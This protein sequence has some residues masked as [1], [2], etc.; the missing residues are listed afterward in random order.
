MSKSIVDDEINRIMDKI[1]ERIK[2]KDL[3]VYDISQA[4]FYSPDE[5]MSVMERP[6]KNISV[7]YEI[8]DVVENM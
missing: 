3:N 1:M 8:L 7:Y 2:Q 6:V 5:F 4:L